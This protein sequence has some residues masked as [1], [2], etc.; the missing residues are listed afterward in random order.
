MNHLVL[1]SLPLL[2]VTATIILSSMFGTIRRGP[3]SLY[4][5]QGRSPQQK[6]SALNFVDRAEVLGIQHVHRNFQVPKRE[7]DNAAFLEVSASV[8]VSDVNNDG[9]YDLFFNGNRQGELNRLYINEAGKRFRLANEE[10]GLANL[11]NDPA[12]TM[13]AVFVDVNNDGFKDLYLANIG[14][15][16]LMLNERGK[17]FRDAS[18]EFGLNEVCHFTTTVNFLDYDRDGF[19]DIY[20][21]NF[22]N[23]QIKDIRMRREI[24]SHSQNDGSGQPNVLLKNIAGKSFK[25]VT[26]E[27]GLADRGLPWAIGVL[28]YNEDGF[29]DIH[30]A[31]DFGID[32]LYMNQNGKSFKDQSDLLGM[33][34]GTASM[35]STVADMDGDLKPEIFV[36]NITYPGRRNGSNALYSFRSG[37]NQFRNQSYREK[38]D[39][40]GFAWGTLAFDPD[41][42]GDLD[43]L[44]VNGYW[45]KGPKEFWYTY[46]SAGTL[47]KFFNSIL[48]FRPK[49]EGTKM[50]ANQRSCL[51]VNDNGSLTDLALESGL[52]SQQ[53]GRAVAS[54]DFDNDGDLD[55]VIA[56]SES[57]PNFYINE[58][59][60]SS[61]WIGLKLIASSSN[62]DLSGIRVKAEWS[63]GSKLLSMPTVN[64]YLSQNDDRIFLGIP[65]DREN[66][67]LK[68][69]ID[70]P[71]GK[72]QIV[73]GLELNRYH[74]LVEPK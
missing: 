9:Y 53:I 52:S 50:A 31:N 43:Y 59:N 46:I 70:W 24:S 45:D 21:G 68:F 20:L 5:D 72:S 61:K 44:V 39:K 48:F 29:L 32:R 60:L 40:C 17:R 42:D 58:S 57:K 25:D 37:E 1:R 23:E 16:I 65:K 15:D 33:Q 19:V 26:K 62:G 74:Q 56:N 73:S 2:V 10:Y 35:S 67:E 22:H 41:R 38:V 71:S 28:D 7:Q 47:P 34:P 66:E 55:L 30:I 54:L 6:T 69:K 18:S 3:F 14:C 36:S 63:S 64:G 51:F 12:V 11:K 13:M 49:T 8:A 4:Q 27:L